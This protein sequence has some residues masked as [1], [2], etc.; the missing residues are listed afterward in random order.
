MYELLKVFENSITRY[1][2][3][4]CTLLL[5]QL[6]VAHGH[7]AFLVSRGKLSDTSSKGGMHAVIQNI[8]ELVKQGS[9][10]SE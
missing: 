7:E 4:A 9:A 10:L 2:A 3:P 6:Q 8:L 5:G 1:L